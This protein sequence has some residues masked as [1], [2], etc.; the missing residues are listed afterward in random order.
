[1][2]RSIIVAAIIISFAILLNGYLDRAA[3]TPHAQ[4]SSQSQLPVGRE[5]SIAVLPFQDFGSSE[6]SAGF[7]D[8]VQQ[9]IISRLT[10]VHDL[11]VVSQKNGAAN[12]LEGSVQRANDRV[13]V[14]VQLVDAKTDTHLWAQR[15]DREITDVF[16]VESDI[17][18]SIADQLGV[19]LSPTE[20]AAIEENRG[21]P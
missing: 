2:N 17:A 15:Y 21:H 16:A 1:M 14:T 7:A 19:R 6:Q 13:R 10:K 11:K 3:R 18:K 4:Q 12:V 20:K 5:K 9:E 8:G